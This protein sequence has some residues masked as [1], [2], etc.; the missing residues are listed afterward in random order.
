M[1]NL[2]NYYL[3][4]RRAIKNEEYTDAISFYTTVLAYN[5][6]EW[7]ASFY[8]NYAKIQLTDFNVLDEKLWDFGDVL[9]TIFSVLAKTPM[10]EE[11]KTDNILQCSRYVSVLL[12]E[13]KDKYIDAQQ[14]AFL[15]MNYAQSQYCT[16]QHC[17]NLLACYRLCYCYCDAIE[18]Y[19]TDNTVILKDILELRKFLSDQHRQD[20][21]SYF[22]PNNTEY[23]KEY[24]DENIS[25][26][27]KLSLKLNG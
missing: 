7:E 16:N 6:N 21:K 24:L 9:Y 13:T 22:K 3:L 5:P 11:W 1:E 15:N 25:K 18:F 17:F 27:Q 2:T 23:S 19:F 4:A 8:T 12:P 14:E 26:L 20:H 10:P